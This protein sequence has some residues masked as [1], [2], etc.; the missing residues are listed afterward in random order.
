MNFYDKSAR[1]LYMRDL[2]NSGSCIY[3]NDMLTALDIPPKTF[4]RDIASL[5]QYLSENGKGELLYDRKKDCYRLDITENLT[6]RDVFA[7][8]KILIESRA[9]NKPE[10]ERLTKKL[11]LTLPIDSRKNVDYR[12]ANERVN[13]LPLQHG[14]PLIDRIWE[15]SGFIRNQEI[16][17]LSYIRLD[18]T[19][20]THEVQPVGVMFSEFYFYLIAFMADKSKDH[21]TIF[22]VDR[23]A[24]IKPTGISCNDQTTGYT[25]RFQE[26]E[27]RQHVLFMY[28]GE[29]KTIRFLY[30]GGLEAVLDRLP[31]AKVESESPDGVIIRAKVFGKGVDMWLQSQGE[32]VVML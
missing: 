9:F 19:K 4:Q 20:R 23:I 7:L 26:A 31:T 13:F 14:K 24:D 32:K 10:F 6:E 2:L 5:R 15:L 12:I 21:P 30:K 18:E 1:L 22:R 25:D 17:Q 28:S 11:L 8:C 27:F 16:I 3:K 29:P